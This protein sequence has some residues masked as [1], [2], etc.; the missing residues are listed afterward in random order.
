M[1]L[2]RDLLARRMRK[3]VDGRQTAQIGEPSH[4]SRIDVAWRN[5]GASFRRRP[6]RARS[7]HI[8]SKS[9]VTKI[10]KL[11]GSPQ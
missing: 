11:G 2:L 9:H 8:R 4:R 7:F 3:A 1:L 5:C 10:S 6:S